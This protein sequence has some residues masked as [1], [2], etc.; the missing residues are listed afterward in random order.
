MATPKEY[1]MKQEFSVQT[2]ED[3][4]VVEVAIRCSRKMVQMALDVARVQVEEVTPQDFQPP[5]LQEGA[6]A[7]PITPIQRRAE[8]DA[9]VDA[10]WQERSNGPVL[11]NTGARTYG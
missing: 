9:F 2:T 5:R 6:L 10:E 3:D 11:P 7:E 8:L 4:D 1:A